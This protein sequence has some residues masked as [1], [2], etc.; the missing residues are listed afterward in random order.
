MK[1]YL[2]HHE[3]LRSNRTLALFAGLTLVFLV[4][5]L[6]RASAAGVD[7]L[8]ITFL[9]FCLIFLFYT[10]NYRTLII[11]ISPEFLELKFGI[12]TWNVPMANIESC[13]P[14]DDL[15]A[16]NKH[17]GAGIH[18]MFVNGQY[19]A[20]WN[21]LEYPRLAITLKRKAGPVQAL[22]FST[23]QPGEI[24]SIINKLLAEPRPPK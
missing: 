1:D 14:D 11:R 5:F 16:L 2:L 9:V 12:F 6:W 15:P 4:L 21:F 19:R 7:G 13:T 8:A 10:V 23:R 24:Q 22:S 18:F 17:G 20:S 3:T